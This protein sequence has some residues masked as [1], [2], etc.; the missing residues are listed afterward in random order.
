MT[1]DRSKKPKPK[2]AKVTLLPTGKIV[3][4]PKSIG[5]ELGAIPVAEVPDADEKELLEVLK[6]LGIDPNSEPTEAQM[7][8]VASRMVTRRF[9]RSGLLPKDEGEE[10]DA[11]ASRL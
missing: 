7:E 3:Q 11:G 10:N 1:E 8:R 5:I 6:E 4:S 9:E 2:P